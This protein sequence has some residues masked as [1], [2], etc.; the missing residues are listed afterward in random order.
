MLRGDDIACAF[1]REWL[2]V[3]S[4]MSAKSNGR[5]SMA[6]LF[7]KAAILAELLVRACIQAEA[8]SSGALLML[9][10]LRAVAGGG[11]VRGGDLA[12]AQ[13]Q[14]QRGEF[15]DARL[16]ARAGVVAEVVALEQA[17]Q[18]F[19]RVEWTAGV[20]AGVGEG[21]AGAFTVAGLV[22]GT[23]VGAVDLGLI[24]VL[25][26]RAQ[27]VRRGGGLGLVAVF[28]ERGG[29][30]QRHRAVARRLLVEL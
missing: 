13:L 19:H 5:P 21:L 26:Q 15:G 10:L 7:T 14:H 20:V 25:Q 12:L 17:L 3:H 9:Q 23:G 27:Q 22:A 29:I 6:A 30:S 24:A 2:P 28:G 16:D 8:Q 1:V 11:V 4:S 18:L